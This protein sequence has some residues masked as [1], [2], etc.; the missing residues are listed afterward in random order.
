MG[1]DGAVSAG[2]LL[3]ASGILAGCTEAPNSTSG[4]G[5][6]NVSGPKVPLPNATAPWIQLSNCTQ[7][8]LVYELPFPLVDAVV[9]D[10]FEVWGLVP[11]LAGINVF[12]LDCGRVLGNGSTYDRAGFFWSVAFVYTKNSSWGQSGFLD[13][14]VLDFATSLDALVANLSAGGITITPGQMNRARTALPGGEDFWTWDVRT[15]GW[16]AQII[17]HH[18]TESPQTNQFSVQLWFGAGPFRKIAANE[19][20]SVFSLTNA[21]S[22]TLGGSSRLQQ[23]IVSPATAWEGSRYVNVEWAWEISSGEYR[24]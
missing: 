19:T 3:V 12:A 20:Y 1:W 7:S 10:A 22:L 16:N 14:Y 24:E 21:G 13:Y 8:V 18:F 4:E 6:T 11:G 17:E 9:P 5:G 15:D 23:A 2:L